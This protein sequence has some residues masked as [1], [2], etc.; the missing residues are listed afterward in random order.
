MSRERVT[1]AAEGCGVY[2]Q[3]GMLMCKG[4]WFSLPKPL[5]IAVWQTWRRAFKA[6]YHVGI[7]PETRLRDIA[8][9]REAVRAARDYLNGVPPTPAQAM[10]TDAI[11][12]DGST[13]RF[14]EGR[15][16]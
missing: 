4:H 3:R 8:A 12:E 7:D 15:M 14:R 5:R 16:L 10:A 11:A 2:V 13:L 6:E 9:Y 1:C